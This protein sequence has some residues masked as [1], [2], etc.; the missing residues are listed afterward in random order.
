MIIV[1]PTSIG[2][3]RSK[4][5][6][7]T[8]SNFETSSTSP[9]FNNLRNCSPYLVR[10]YVNFYPNGVNHLYPTSPYDIFKK[11]TLQTNSIKPINCLNHITTI[12]LAIL[13]IGSLSVTN[14]VTNYK[15][16]K[17][18]GTLNKTYVQSNRNH[19]LFYLL[20]NIQ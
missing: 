10:L 8:N 17:T 11:L 3:T 4:E 18:I 14:D 9:T 20:L 13:T 2:K 19:R 1:Y 15:Y 7:K 6:D 5:S 12:V 16:N